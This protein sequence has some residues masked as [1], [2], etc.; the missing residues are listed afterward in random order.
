MH[1]SEEL[2]K[3][4]VKVTLEQVT[5]AQKAGR[6]IALLFPKHD[7]RWGLMAKATSQQLYPP[8]KRS[9]TYF[10]GGLCGPR[11]RSGRVSKISPSPGFDPRTVQ[12]VTSRY[13]D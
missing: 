2:L 12:P 8:V 9:G 6:G 4:K 5:K 3:L 7:I 11:R 13:T 10:T 1:M